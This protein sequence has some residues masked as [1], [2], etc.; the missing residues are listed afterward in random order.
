MPWTQVACKDGAIRSFE[1]CLACDP[2]CCDLEVREAIFHQNKHQDPHHAGDSI[3]VTALTGCLRQVY[4]ERNIDY[5]AHPMH[6]WFTLRGELIHRL[7][8]MPDREGPTEQE[9]SERRF[10]AMLNGTPITGKV[11]RYKLRFLEHG[12]L[13]DWKS[14]GDNGMQFIV[15]DGAKDEHIWQMNIYAWLLRQN[16]LPVNYIQICYLSLMAIVRTGEPVTWF[17][18]LN[19]APARAGKRAHMVGNP[20]LTKSYLSGKKKW[21]CTYQVPHVPMYD[22]ETITA[23]MS[24][25]INHLAAAFREGIIPPRCD[26]DMQAWRC[27]EYCYARSQCQQIEECPSGKLIDGAWML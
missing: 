5:A 15:Y 12:I 7:V 27:E 19:A 20:V 8:E 18:Y 22:D 10:T 23:F 14:I 13:K 17:E 25:R 2:A 4:L 16:N 1:D 11:D 26:P 24:P 21:A 9:F 3:S 6:R